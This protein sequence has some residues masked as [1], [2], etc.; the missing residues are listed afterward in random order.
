MKSKLSTNK[1]NRYNCIAMMV[2]S[3]SCLYLQ[4]SPYMSTEFYITNQIEEGLIIKVKRSK[5]E[6]TVYKCGLC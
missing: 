5:H 1:F 6:R 2:V 3:T 4:E